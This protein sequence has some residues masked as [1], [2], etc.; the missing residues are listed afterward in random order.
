MAVSRR[1]FI[2]RTGSALAGAALAPS[3]LV[4]E[5]RPAFRWAARSA[6]DMPAPDMA[7]LL[8]QRAAFGARPGDVEQTRQTGTDA[9]I[10]AQLNPDG[11]PDPYTDAVLAARGLT[12]YKQTSKQLLEGNANA[13]AQHLVAGTLLR[14]WFSPRQLYEVMVDFWNDHFTIYA[15]QADAGKVRIVDDRDVAR[16]HA[17]STFKTLLTASAHSPAMIMF[18]DNDT[19]QAR[20]INENYAREIMELH[21]LGV[22][23]AGVPYTED[24]IKQVA[25]CFTGWNWV[26]R[27]QKDTDIVGS[28]VYMDNIHDQNAK[29]VLGVSIPARQGQQD[30]V[31]VIDILSRHEATPRFIATKLIR[32]LVCDDPVADVP[33]LVDRVAGVFT[34]KGGDVKAMLRTILTSPEFATSFGHFGGRYSRPLD[35]AAR[36]VRALGGQPADFDALAVFATSRRGR[37]VGVLPAAGQVPF[38]WQTPDGYPDVKIAWSSS[39]GLLA[40]WN[41]ALDLVGSLDR[42]AAGGPTGGG[43]DSPISVID[44]TPPDRRTAGEVA[45]YWIDRILHRPML[46]ADRAVLVDFVTAGGTEFDTLTAAQR[47]R[48]REMVALVLDSP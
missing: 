19:N 14:Q 46:S 10:E 41:Y 26:R 39:S 11:L 2:G 1:A 40:R 37:A 34:A 4:R 24:D 13:S 5:V 29:K 12:S 9:W 15:G 17:L 18:L 25:R 47:A 16:A 35:Y 32:R 38:Y 43:I 28:F 6:A 33:A 22:A 21:S 23:V 45:D 8:W 30:G 3:A 42:N 44:Q 48:I 36:A 31:Q 27:S 7:A 20:Q